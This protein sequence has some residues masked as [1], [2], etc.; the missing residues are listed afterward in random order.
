M[1]K[2]LLILTFS[3]VSLG[4]CIGQ[5]SRYQRADQ[6]YRQHEYAKAI[7]WYEHLLKKE[8][9]A[10]PTQALNNLA[11]CHY[12]L[13]NYKKAEIWLAKMATNPDVSPSGLF[14][15]GHVLMIN[16]KPEAAWE[17]FLRVQ[18]QAPFVSWLDA[19]L[20]GSLDSTQWQAKKLPINSRETDFGPAFWDKGLI[21]ASQRN[22]STAGVVHTSRTTESPLLNLYYSEPRSAD[23]WTR[24]QPLPGNVNSKLHDGPAQPAP[25]G[26]YLYVNQ[27]RKL[28]RSS[29]KEAKS[30][31]LVSIVIYEN[32]KGHWRS[33]QK[34]LLPDLPVSYLHPAVS[35]DGNWLYFASDLP[36]GEGGLDLYK[37]RMNGESWGTP[38]NLGPSVNTPYNEAYPF[39]HP[40]GTLYFASEGHPGFGGWDLFR[41]YPRGGNWTSPANLG[42]PINSR[43]DDLSLI[44]DSSKTTCYFASNRGKNSAKDHIYQATREVP[45]FQD[46]PQQESPALCYRFYEQGTEEDL[47]YQLIYEWDFGDG[48]TAQGVRAKHCFEKPGVYNIALNVIDSLSGGNMFNEATYQLEINKPEGPWILATA[49]PADPLLYHL[50]AS[51]SYMPGLSIS[52]WHWEFGEGALADGAKVDHRFPGPG[53]WS[54]QLGAIAKSDSSGEQQMPCVVNT[55][56]VKA[57]KMVSTPIRKEPEG[58]LGPFM[59][60]PSS[61]RIMGK[62]RMPNAQLTE[63]KIV[64]KELANGNIF[65]ETHSIFGDGSFITQLPTGKNYQCEIVFPGYQP[66]LTPLDLRDYYGEAEMDLVFNLV[67]N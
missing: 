21:F 15:Y 45:A 38:I 58:K 35:P 40:D 66:L 39:L 54:I 59:K 46:C 19:L 27:S 1:K 26:N 64:W 24:P 6:L 44:M 52:G 3:L 36:G 50:D 25:D 34:A 65:R 7:E 47:P 61:L 42:T 18:E 37:V 30:G 33:P 60:Q 4:C 56:T 8:K 11:N 49:D 53:E 32:H 41:T 20:K 43:W 23:K 5:S 63:G 55:V 9:E 29:R 2:Y 67:P 10:L 12:A 13:R 31:P 22:N 51:Q 28:H 16:G 14:R 17:Q 57:P 62:V 48:H